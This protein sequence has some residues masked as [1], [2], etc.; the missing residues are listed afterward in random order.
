[1]VSLS[2]SYWVG[3]G[4]SIP[5]LKQWCKMFPPRKISKMITTHECGRQTNAITIFMPASIP[6]VKFGQKIDVQVLILVNKRKHN[7]HIKFVW[8]YRRVYVSSIR[9]SYEW[10]WFK[11]TSWAFCHV[12]NIWIIAS[13]HVQ[14]PSS[15]D[16]AA[17]AADKQAITGPSPEY[18]FTEPDVRH[19]TRP[20]EQRPS[21]MYY[22]PGSCKLRLRT[23]KA[24]SGLT[25]GRG[26]ETN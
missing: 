15:R 22:P 21:C 10:C 19:E 7:L 5:S 20:V 23:F 12:T 24:P 8:L 18:M 11:R 25:D 3:A 9:G 4:T 14:Q 26:V 2:D 16:A 17:A 6:P 1:M 13:F